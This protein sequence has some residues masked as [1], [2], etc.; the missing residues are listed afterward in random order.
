MKI[1]GDDERNINPTQDLEAEE[2]IR[3][4][5]IDLNENICASLTRLS[6]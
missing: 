2:D 6:E 5:L 3:V 1:D 4:H